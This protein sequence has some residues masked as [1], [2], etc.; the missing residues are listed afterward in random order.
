M[1][2]LRSPSDETDIFSLYS[3]RTES[4]PSTPTKTHAIPPIVS[5]FR[6]ARSVA[7]RNP[8]HLDNELAKTTINA[9]SA[10][11]EDG[12][13][14]RSRVAPAGAN[15]MPST[16]PPKR[17][18]LADP[19]VSS[20]SPGRSA[21][22]LIN[23]WESMSPRASTFG[24]EQQPTSRTATIRTPRPS[25]KNLPPPPSNPPDKKRSPLRQSFRNI[26]SVFG[27]KPKNKPTDV[28]NSTSDDP[29]V[30]RSSSSETSSDTALRSGS[31]LYFCNSSGPAWTPCTAGLYPTR[32]LLQGD[33]TQKI[34]LSECT[35][36]RSVSL[37]ELD[38]E[39]L[40]TLPRSGGGDEN[41]DG[42]KVFEV[43]FGAQGED[44]ERTHR[45]AVRTVKD[46]AWWVS[47]IW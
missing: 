22:D 10:V 5:P 11:P 19:G 47:G 20:P 18:S 35:D 14:I 43:V 32:I 13:P 28:V 8:G 40:D 7:R 12:E 39:Q 1:A 36:V 23:Q 2:G 44:G 33:S 46:R 24:Q 29:F 26:L 41:P 3:Q 9:L 34:S 25:T 31:V 45:F 30:S 37:K 16:P 42:P 27:K 4:G 17:V 21:K 38:S 15:A 6:R